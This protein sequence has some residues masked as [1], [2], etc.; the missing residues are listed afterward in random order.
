V[1]ADWLIDL[2]HSRLKL[3]RWLGGRR[4]GPVEAM[5]PDAFDTWL[6]A[7]PD[8]DDERFWLAAVPRPP[9]VDR[10]IAGIARAGADGRVVTTGSAALP[11]APAYPGLG[12]DRWLAMQ[13]LWVSMRAPFCVVD[14]GTATTIDAV[15]EQGRHR[16]GWILPGAAASRAGLLA[17]ATG[18]ALAPD[19][20]QAEQVGAIERA[21]IEFRR[22]IP[23]RDPALVL[24]GGASGSL[25]SALVQ[26]RLEP[27]LVLTGL[28]MA[29][30]RWWSR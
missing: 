12:V 7:R 18:L 3:A 22:M 6:G 1:P 2:G 28:A 23:G 19:P 5:P 13:P 25:Q 30:E 14:A 26:S 17:A 27:D 21:L 29:V 16:G 15:D 11:V 4:L 10:V 8:P 9:I 24:T 20:G